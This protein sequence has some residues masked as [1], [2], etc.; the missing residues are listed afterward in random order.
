MR[1]P[2][3]RT[4]GSGRQRAASA[5][6]SADCGLD[7]ALSRRVA[8]RDYL[9]TWMDL[10]HFSQGTGQ[11]RV[12]NTSVQ[13]C[14]VESSGQGSQALQ[15]C[16][17]RRNRRLLIWLQPSDPAE[18][19]LVDQHIPT[20]V[21]LLYSVSDVGIK[22]PI[23]T[24]NKWPRPREG[25]FTC[26]RVGKATWRDGRRRWGRQSGSKSRLRPMLAV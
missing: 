11:G 8:S 2:G 10:L 25:G 6:D 16:D 26:W 15:A 21:L 3:S 13:C 12:S 19:P 23:A 14:G 20:S 18:D 17:G 4:P 1:F 24:L 5:W 7:C 9:A 22:F